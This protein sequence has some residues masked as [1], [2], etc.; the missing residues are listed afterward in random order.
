MLRMHSLSEAFQAIEW[1]LLH[2]FAAGVVHAEFS[3][4]FSISGMS[5]MKIPVTLQINLSF[6]CVCARMM[7]YRYRALT[8][9]H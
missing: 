3:V 9:V 4:L 6:A 8:Q 2:G 5:C 7:I 1:G